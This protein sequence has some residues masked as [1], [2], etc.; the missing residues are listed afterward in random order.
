MSYQ[1]LDCSYRSKTKFPGGK[2]PACDSYNIRKPAGMRVAD[3]IKE[4][5][6]KVEIFTLVLFWGVL[7]WGV[8][9]RYLK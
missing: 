7:L 4:P 5:K 2:C 6:T 9:D 3:D 1:C 8:W